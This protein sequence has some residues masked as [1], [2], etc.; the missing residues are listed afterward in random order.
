MSA[1]SPGEV[2][3]MRL[4]CAHIRRRRPSLRGG[5]ARHKSMQKAFFSRSDSLGGPTERRGECGSYKDRGSSGRMSSVFVSY[6]AFGQIA[7]QGNGRC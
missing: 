7:Q 5:I 6:E 3:A 4:D 1:R 2:L